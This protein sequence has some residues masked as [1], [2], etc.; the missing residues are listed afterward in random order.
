MFDPVLDLV[1]TTPK[2][3]ATYGTPDNVP[4]FSCN[5]RAEELPILAT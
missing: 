3:A 2:F 1:T 5:V 4:A